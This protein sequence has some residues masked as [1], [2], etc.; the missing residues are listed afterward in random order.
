MEEVFRLRSLVALWT[1]TLSPSFSF[2]QSGG[3]LKVRN[4]YGFDFAYTHPTPFYGGEVLKV[5]ISPE[6]YV[7]LTLRRP[8]SW[9]L[10]YRSP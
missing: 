8:H 5:R 10:E 3:C 4:L 9:C 7:H 6:I 1:C 2:F